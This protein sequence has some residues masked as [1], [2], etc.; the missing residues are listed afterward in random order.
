MF[1]TNP[2]LIVIKCFK[3]MDIHAQNTA[4][5]IAVS[6]Y[7]NREEPA[8]LRKGAEW[9]TLCWFVLLLLRSH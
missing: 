9:L 7:L 4:A 5:K 2:V 1:Y 8:P 3:R 6:I